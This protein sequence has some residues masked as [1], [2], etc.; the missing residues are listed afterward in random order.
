MENEIGLVAPQ[1]FGASDKNAALA[2]LLCAFLG[3]AGI[4]RF[5]VGKIGTGIIQLLTVGGLGIWYLIDL[6][7]LGFGEFTDKDGL[8][9]RGSTQ[10]GV[11]LILCY[12][13]GVLGIHRFYVG[14]WITGLLM[15]VTFGGGGIWWLIDIC[16]ICS[17]KFTD[18]TGNLLITA[19]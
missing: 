11:T 19:G 9:L 6:T 4:H 12:L 8:K 15:L 18:A 13:V 1:E 2:C 3:W 17:D 14:K 7:M 10:K 16:L 5:Y